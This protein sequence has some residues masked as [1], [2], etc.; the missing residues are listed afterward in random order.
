MS[1]MIFLILVPLFTSVI[2]MLIYK[3]QGKA[4]ELFSLDLVQFVYLFLM[5]PTLF[6]WLKTFLFYLLRNELEP[7]LSVT[8]IFIVDTIFT[9]IAI[10]VMAAIAIHSLTKTFWIKRH[11]NPHFD[12]YHLS[13]YF[14]LWWSHII[15]WG[16]AMLLIS[17]VSL[18]N[19]FAPLE[20][21]LAKG[22]FIAIQV[23]GSLT[24]LFLFLA[25]WMSDPGQGNFMRLMKLLLVLFSVVHIVFYFV[26]DPQFNSRFMM[27][28]F[29]LSVFVS[30]AAIGGIFERYEKLGW[31]RRILLHSGWGDNKGINIFKKK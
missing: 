29:S 2:G 3:F 31:F 30:A 25:I 21:F 22:A 17:F 7:S 8:E 20:L 15:I 28:W 10:F 4:K 24:G 19:V 16:G 23:L 12:I 1:R 14:H 6:V 13:E 27:Y 11:H 18:A 26:F 9:V 5:A